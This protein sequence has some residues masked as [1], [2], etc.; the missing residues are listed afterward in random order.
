[1]KQHLKNS[2]FFIVFA[3]SLYLVG[4]FGVSIGFSQGFTQANSRLTPLGRVAFTEGPAWHPEL[5]VL[6]SDIQNNRIMR[7]SKSGEITVYRTP[8]V[9]ANGLLFDHDGR[10]VACEGGNRRITRTESDGSITVLA[11]QFEGKKFNSPNDIVV[12]SR[13]NLFFTDP[14]YGDRTGIEQFDSAGDSIEGVYRISVDGGVTRV[15]GQEISR[16]NGIAVSPDDRYLFV[17]VNANDDQGSERAVYRYDLK[18]DGTVD[19][20]SQLRLFDWGM[21]RGPD[22]M[23]I[24]KEGRLYVTAGLNYAS[25]PHETS[26]RH[27]A[28]VYVISPE[29]GLLE[30]IA[31]PID[32]VTNC[33][34][35]G[36]DRKT[37]YVTA[38][39]KLWSIELSI[40]G[41]TV[42]DPR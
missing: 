8:S 22:G 17:A 20:D 12:D 21:D 13:G 24:D 31:V 37:L 3:M 2:P 9:K 11:D 36:D 10:L 18:Q 42:W 34:F 40:E 35:G 28:G 29:G 33:S 27:R 23:A 4:G 25:P 14:R 7:A 30:T 16:P 39:H 26:G 5:G 1:M 15:L 32:M 19:S 6:F 38:G 41:H